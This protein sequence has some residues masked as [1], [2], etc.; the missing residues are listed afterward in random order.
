MVSDRLY[1]LGSPINGWRVD[2][3]GDGSLQRLSKAA[4]EFPSP[5]GQRDGNC[6]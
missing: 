4:G 5:T 6:R 3:V 1:P 2:C